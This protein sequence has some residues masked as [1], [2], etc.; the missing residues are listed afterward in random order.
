MFS[1]IL[2]NEYIMTA[3]GNLNIPR[4]CFLNLISAK[5]VSPFEYSWQWWQN[6]FQNIQDIFVSRYIWLSIYLSLGRLFG[7][8]TAT[9]P[10]FGPIS[11]CCQLS[12]FYTFCL[13]GKFLVVYSLIFSFSW[14]VCSLLYIDNLVPS[15][16][17]VC[18]AVPPERVKW[19]GNIVHYCCSFV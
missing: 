18:K 12:W 19:V 1:V 2:W 9:R 8:P 4:C 3:A 13:L 11:Q 14:W 7:R 16:T 5:Y 17:G 15:F 6:I 10:P